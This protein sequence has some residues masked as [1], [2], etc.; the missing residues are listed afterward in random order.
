MDTNGC[1]LSGLDGIGFLWEHTELEVHALFRP[2]ED[3]PFLQ[4]RSMTCRW[5]HPQ[6]AIFIS[7]TTTKRLHYPQLQT[8]TSYSNVYLVE[9]PSIWNQK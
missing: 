1:L 6:E 8:E 5:G 7:T 2:S 4:Q 9:D 3:T